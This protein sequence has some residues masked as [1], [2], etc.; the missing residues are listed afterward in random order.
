MILYF[1]THTL[2]CRA[3]SL[4]FRDHSHPPKRDTCP[5]LLRDH[6]HPP[7]GDTCPTL[8]RDHSHP[9][10]RDTCGSSCTTLYMWRGSPDPSVCE[11]GFLRAIP[12]DLGGFRHTIPSSDGL[13]HLGIVCPG[14][15]PILRY[16]T[17]K[18]V[19]GW[20]RCEEEPK[21]VCCICD[22]LLLFPGMFIRYTVHLSVP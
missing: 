4:L 12:R 13:R 21:R 5:T 11:N 9:P 8:K 17:Q 20:D 10:K 1:N 14:P 6:S 3:R 7:K 15:P 19:G 22:Q 18:P 16:G 2:R